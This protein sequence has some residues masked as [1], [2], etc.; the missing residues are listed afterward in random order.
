[1]DSGLLDARNLAEC[2]EIGGIVD[3]GFSI[4]FKVDRPALCTINLWKN[5]LGKCDFTFA[6]QIDWALSRMKCISEE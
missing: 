2:F 6:A 1:M 5:R 3:V 4:N